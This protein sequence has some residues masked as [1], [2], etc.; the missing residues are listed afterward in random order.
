M[1]RLLEL[2]NN[3]STFRYY[4]GVGNFNQNN[5]PFGPDRANSESSGQPYIKE[6]KYATSVAGIADV[7]THTAVDVIRMTKFLKDVPRGPLFIAKQVGLQMMNPRLQSL[8]DSPTNLSTSGQGFLRNTANLISNTTNGIKNLVG[9]NRI[10]TPTNFLAQIANASS[11]RGIPRQGF[12]LEVPDKDK[13]WYITAELER[14]NFKQNNN[15]IKTYR[16]FAIPNDLK[17]KDKKGYG[18]DE[19]KNIITYTGGAN[20]ILGIGSTTI[21]SYYSTIAASDKSLPKSKQTLNGFT[22]M[23]PGLLFNIDKD[24]TI[25]T[26]ISPVTSA[27]GGYLYDSGDNPILKINKVNLRN[28]DFRA[29][30]ASTDPEYAKELRDKNIR[31]TDYEKFNV[32]SRIGTINTNQKSFA[33]V[34]N[35]GINMMAPYYSE[36]PV[37]NDYTED[38][39]GQVITSQGIRDLIKFRIKILDNDKPG[40]GTYLIFRAFIN[41]MNDTMEAEWKPI[42]YA[43]RGESFYNYEGFTANYSVNFT[44]VAFSELEMKPLYQKLNYLKSS[45]APDYKNNRMRG[46]IAE[47]TIGDYIKYQPGI[48]TSL[49]TSLPEGA[50]WE[51]AMEE[52]EGTNSSDDIMHELPQILK[53]DLS[54]TPIYNFLPRKSSES[55]FIGIDSDRPRADWIK[56]TQA[57]LKPVK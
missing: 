1:S 18:E 34:A 16:N 50:P 52:P 44:I 17:R 27:N 31:I 22:P 21:K 57:K 32:H 49:G 54:F 10:W 51:I 53:V 47:L 14:L 41:S 46:N 56:G 15:L 23:T 4:T 26:S 25:I 33:R 2:F 28:T 12:S 7:A 42:K 48:I 13:A 5:L 39:N 19:S 55:P 11:R 24:S 9:S 29:Y 37:P 45:L 38:I 40:Y 36:G 35:D 20:S 30:K 43:G 6:P 3:V 8:A